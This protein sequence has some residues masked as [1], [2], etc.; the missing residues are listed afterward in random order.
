MFHRPLQFT[1]AGGMRVIEP[2]GPGFKPS[3]ERKRQHLRLF[4]GA[5]PPDRAWQAFRPVER[6]A[7][8]VFAAA[9]QMTAVGSIE[10]S[11]FIRAD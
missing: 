5:A 4:S 6:S 1:Y 10:R 9:Q 2:A 11:E 7:R 3:D 8:P